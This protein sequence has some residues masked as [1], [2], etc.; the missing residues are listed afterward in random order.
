MDWKQV[1]GGKKESGITH[2]FGPSNQ[3]KK[4]AGERKV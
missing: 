1:G 4:K 2:S 3:V